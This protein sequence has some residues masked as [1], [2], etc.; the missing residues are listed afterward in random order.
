MGASRNATRIAVGL[1]IAG[2]LTALS[3]MLWAEDM[4]PIILAVAGIVGTLGVAMTIVIGWRLTGRLMSRFEQTTVSQSQTS[5]SLGELIE[6]EDGHVLWANDAYGAAVGIDPVGPPIAL[7]EVFDDDAENMQA[8]QRLRASARSG[9]V[10]TETIQVPADRPGLSPKWLS[11]SAGPAVGG[12]GAVTWTVA[13]VTGVQ[14]KL[15]ESEHDYKRL[16]DLVDHM[17]VGICSLEENGKFVYAN[18]TL[19]EWLDYAP[20]D[21]IEGNLRFDDFVL[22]G[23]G[24][25]TASQLGRV[26]ADG[27]EIRLRGRRGNTFPVHISQTM[28]YDDEGNVTGLRSI[29]RDISGEREL[30]ET[31]RQAEEGFRRFFDYAPVGIVMVDGDG[32]VVETNAAFHSMVGIKQDVERMPQIM[33]LVVDPDRERVE[34]EFARVRSGETPAAPLEVR[35]QG[36]AAKIVQIYA[37][38]T[39]DV[40]APVPTSDLIVYIVDATEQKNLEAQFTQSQKMQAVGQLAGG[41]AHDF[42][43]LLTAIIGYSD[44]LLQRHSVADQSFGDGSCRSSRMPTGPLIWSGSCWRSLVGKRFSLKCWCCPMSWPSSPIF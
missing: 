26:D 11:V 39:G 17:P 9:I 33:D 5:H 36:P 25:I 24:A 8:I 34:N 20:Q 19:A 1:A 13:D 2:A 43:N 16:A 38:R 15:T 3:L 14:R 41:I 28:A 22:S 44:L 6:D 29:V 21:L 12:D 4:P 7:G 40:T 27:A 32:Q 42:N 10:S 18:A 30:E 31:L 37:R 35:L 23:S